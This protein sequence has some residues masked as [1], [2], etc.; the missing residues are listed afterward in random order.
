PWLE[1]LAADE[2]EDGRRRLA[3][4]HLRECPACGRELA[5]W[6][7]LVASAAAPAAVIDA[8]VRAIDWDALAGKIVAGVE[9]QGVRRRRP[10]AIVSLPFLAAA[11]VLAVVIGLGVFFWARSSGASLPPRPGDRLAAGAMAR[12]QSG[13]AREEAVAYLQQSQLMLTDLLDGCV[14]EKMA[15]GEIRLYSRQAKQLLLKKKYFQPYLSETSWAK[16]RSVSE[17]IDWLNYEILQ[18][19][20]RQLCG[21]IGR[22]QKIMEDERLLLKIRLAE[23]ELAFQPYQEV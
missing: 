10:P 8:Q 19:D 21:Q 7:S 14:N 13:L 6:R 16:V 23:K 17:R 1:W 11:A 2:L 18:L 3:Q 4:A 9:G 20:E 15:P 22:L 5:A 12:L